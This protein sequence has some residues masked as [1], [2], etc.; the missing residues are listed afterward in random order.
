MNNRNLISACFVLAMHC[1]SITVNAQ[2]SLIL[3]DSLV[4]SINPLSDLDSIVKSKSHKA[5][6]ITLSIKTKLDSATNKLNVA[7]DS[8]NALKL[9]TGQYVEK[10]NNLYHSFQDKTI[11]KLTNKSDSVQ[12]FLNDKVSTMDSI[13]SS[14]TH[15]LDSLV[16]ANGGKGL[17]DL[18]ELGDKF[19]PKVPELP[20]T[21]GLNI[22]SQTPNLGAK[23]P[24]MKNPVNTNHGLGSV[25][26]PEVKG[27]EKLTEVQDIISQ[28]SKYGD[29]ISEVSEGA[30]KMKNGEGSEIIEKTIEKEAMKLDGIADLSKG[31]KEIDALQKQVES[32]KNT[33]EKK[34]ELE[35]MAKKEFVDHFAGKEEILNKKLDDIAK[36]QLKYRN[37]AD[38]RF[39]PKRPPNEMKGKPFIERLIPAL[40]FQAFTGTDFMMDV[41]P[42]IGYRFTGRI[43]GGVGGYRRLIY[44]GDEKSLQAMKVNG[45]RL[46]NSVRIIKNFHSY[47]EVEQYQ[48]KDVASFKITNLRETDGWKTKL[49]IG[50]Y[51]TYAIG[52]RFNGHAVLLYDVI[53]IKDFPRA[54]NSAIRFG[55]DY[56]FK[57]KKK[58]VR[59]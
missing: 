46:Y 45:Y 47:I 16:K 8:L 12:S 34:Q 29:Q 15:F 11:K 3:K 22:P 31:Q 40:T 35:Q 14:K 57:K 28:A 4:N 44:L 24:S 25:K 54:A 38:A 36:I 33:D 52:K 39:L 48:I 17:K 53:K 55:I 13:I 20:N 9:S 19:N 30:E 27:L 41:S 1:I 37:V 5:D 49:N 56:Q 58:V 26:M 7:V 43:R 21:A 50:I 59:G 32:L 42:S 23:I 2:S 18:P 10:L 6:S 51:H